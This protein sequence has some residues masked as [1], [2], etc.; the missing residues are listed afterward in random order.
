MT[1]PLDRPPPADW[2][3]ICVFCGAR[4]GLRPAYREAAAS[5][6]GLIASQGLELVYGG[7]NIGLMGAVANAC[8][9]AGGRVTGVIPESLV[10]REVAGEP[11][12]HDGITRLEIVDSMHTR[13]ARMAELADGFI[14]LP[15][16]IGTFEELFEILTWAQLGFHRKP[17][18]LLD[19]LGYFDPLLRLCDQA[20]TEGFL[21]PEHRA[22][23]LDATDPAVL[24]DG[25]AGFRSPDLTAWIR[26]EREL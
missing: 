17:V 4:A 22:L 18:G 5:L 13:K 16:G 15:G 11:V 26:T 10:G 12:A 9:E 19:V 24:L 20:V 23:L 14:A 2:R 8:L 7:G 25:M 6:G 3:R 1:N 21:A